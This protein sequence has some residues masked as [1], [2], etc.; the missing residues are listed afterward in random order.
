MK[1]KYKVTLR[2]V[3]T[4]EEHTRLAIGVSKEAA[5]NRAIE[6]AR[7]SL[8]TMAERKYE[9]FEVVACEPQS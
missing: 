5:G 9:K 1:T 7:G 6:K 8:E 3:A 4:G 2:R